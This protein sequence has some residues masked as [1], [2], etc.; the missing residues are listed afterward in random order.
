MLAIPLLATAGVGYAIC[1]FLWWRYRRRGQEKR[2]EVA[3]SNPFELTSALQFGV[4]FA[5]IL[6]VAKAA[7][8]YLGDAGVYISSMASGLTDV[9]A[10]TLSMARLSGTSVTPEVAARAVVLATLANTA[11]KAGYALILGSPEL[12]KYIAVSFGVLFGVGAVAAFV[13]IP[14]S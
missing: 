9:D 7:Q 12:R 14:W 1:G 13:F 2:E 10:I 3:A 5:V 4:I 6:F 8:V 11:V